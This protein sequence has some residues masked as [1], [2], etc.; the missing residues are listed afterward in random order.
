MFE[1]FREHSDI[2]STRRIPPTKQVGQ[3]QVPMV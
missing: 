1:S 3:S 2:Q